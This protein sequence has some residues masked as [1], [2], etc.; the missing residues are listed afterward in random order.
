MVVKVNLEFN[1]LVIGVSVS[2]ELLWLFLYLYWQIKRH[3]SAHLLLRARRKR[4]VEWVLVHH[5]V[6][7]QGC[8]VNLWD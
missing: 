2:A 7:K 6:I 4:R 8:P 5:Y 3:W 1:G